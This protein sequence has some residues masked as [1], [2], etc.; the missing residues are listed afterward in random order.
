MLLP[1]AKLEVMEPPA[2]MVL[3]V[4]AEKLQMR[5][6]LLANMALAEAEAERMALAQTDR[7]DSYL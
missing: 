3:V 7:K 2:C 1:V 6:R 5:V 4:L